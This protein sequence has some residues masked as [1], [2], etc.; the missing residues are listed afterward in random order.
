MVSNNEGII[1][2][3]IINQFLQWMIDTCQN[4]DS[5]K[6]V[7]NEAMADYSI[8]QK[9]SVGNGGANIS[10]DNSSVIPVVPLSTVKNELNN[11][12]SSRGMLNKDDYP[13]TLKGALNLWNNLATFASTKVVV[14]SGLYCP[15]PVIMYKST[16]TDFLSNV[17]PDNQQEITVSDIYTDTEKMLEILKRYSKSHKFIY[18]ISAFCCSSSSSSC[19]SSSSSSHF[20]VYMAR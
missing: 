15:N 9:A 11:F 17:I 6:N 7:P 12:L 13:I 14:A 8:Q 19:S 4:I 3:N 10:I 5:Y 18:N 2:G 20:I 1:Y 16:N